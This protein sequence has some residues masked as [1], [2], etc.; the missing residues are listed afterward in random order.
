MVGKDDKVKF[1]VWPDILIARGKQ[2]FCKL[3]VK[4]YQMLPKYNDESTGIVAGI[5]SQDKISV[6]MRH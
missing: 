4:N 3:E 2:M 6:F 1:Q 5:M